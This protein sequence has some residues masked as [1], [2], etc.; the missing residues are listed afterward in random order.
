MESVGWDVGLVRLAPID[1]ELPWRAGPFTCAPSRSGLVV[2][3]TR[4][5]LGAADTSLHG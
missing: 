2:R 1:R 5:A 3:F 4:F